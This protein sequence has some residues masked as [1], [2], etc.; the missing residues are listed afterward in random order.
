MRSESRM[1][2]SKRR[3]QPFIRYLGRWLKQKEMVTTLTTVLK[4]SSV[5]LY[6][7]C[8]CCCNGLAESD[9]YMWLYILAMDWWLFRDLFSIA[10]VVGVVWLFSTRPSP[11]WP[12]HE[13]PFFFVVACVKTTVE[14]LPQ[15]KKTNKHRFSTQ[16]YLFSS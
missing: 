2:P 13:G 5:L 9:L 8:C 6:A 12:L 4:K 10:V 16:L 7:S 14:T 11:Q 15:K 1:N 3:N